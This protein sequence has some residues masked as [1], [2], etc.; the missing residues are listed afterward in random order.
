MLTDS[1]PVAM[2]FTSLA[3]EAQVS[4]RTLYTHWGSIDKLIAE[5]VTFVFLDDDTDLQSLS[6]RERLT[7]LLRMAR[8]RMGDP[9]TA[10]AFSMLIARAV[11]EPEAVEAL[12][13]IATRGRAEFEQH[14]ASVSVTQYELIIGPLFHAAYVAHEPLT[15]AGID[16]LAE[17][18]LGVL[19]PVTSK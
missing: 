5:A 11:R 6:P 9:L 18:A 15:D 16:E 4:R 3:A 1:D 10:I 19:G 2:T 12:K 13:V 17:Y 7:A 14:V 8:D